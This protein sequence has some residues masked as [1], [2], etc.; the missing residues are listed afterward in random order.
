MA[1]AI[2]KLAIRVTWDGSPNP[3][4]GGFGEPSHV[5]FFPARAVPAK[6]PASYSTVRI[7][8]R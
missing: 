3:V 1:F 6:L 2:S 7:V 4:L 5:T 8:Y